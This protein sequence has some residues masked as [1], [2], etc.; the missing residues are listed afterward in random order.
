MKV[1]ASC[2]ETFIDHRLGDEVGG[3]AGVEGP[4]NVEGCR[5]KAP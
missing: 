5:P 3:L 2:L 1:F 4:T